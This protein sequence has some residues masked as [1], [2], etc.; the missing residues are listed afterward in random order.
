MGDAW[1]LNRAIMADESKVALAILEEDFCSRGDDEQEVEVC[2]TG[3]LIVTGYMAVL[4]GEEITQIEVALMRKCWSEGTYY[5]RE[6][7]IL[8]T[9]VGR[10]K[11]NFRNIQGLH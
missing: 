3:S 8:L 2:L 5:K 1:I 9:L 10:F 6:P 11:Q 4:R 7:H